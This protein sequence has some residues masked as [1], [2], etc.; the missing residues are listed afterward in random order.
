MTEKKIVI[1]TASYVLSHV[2]WSKLGYE[3][4][5][6]YAFI[7]R[8]NVGKSTLINMLVDRKNLARTSKTPGKTK[9]INLYL[10]NDNWNIVDLP[11]Y[12]YAKVSRTE[13]NEWSKN[14]I[15]YLKNRKNLVTIF[16]LIDSSIPPQKIDIEFINFIGEMMLPFSL[17]FTKT[18]KARSNELK[19]NINAFKNEL[20]KYWE[21]LPPIFFSSSKTMEGRSQLLGYINELS[22][23][24]SLS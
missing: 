1:H 5:H 18:D 15:D 2:N 17:I 22:D 14:T 7:G 8:S 20:L 3:K 12:G 21:E 11:G 9:N 16:I 4:N 19:N 10:I 24:I 6:E 23:N 13:R